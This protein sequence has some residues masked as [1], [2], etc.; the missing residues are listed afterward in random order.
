DFGRTIHIKKANGIS[1][2]GGSR[3]KSPEAFFRKKMKGK[4][5]FQSDIFAV[6]CVFYRLFQTK[7]PSWMDE[8]YL[9]NLKGLKKSPLEKQQN[10]IKK[11]RAKTDKRRSFLATKRTT[12]ILSVKEEVEFLVL[13]MLSIDP[14]QRS[15]AAKLRA[16]CERI[17]KRL[18]T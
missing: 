17:Y 7:L 16:E 4:D 6:G 5:Y 9:K 1:T 3:Y 18:E 10:F 11:I 14:V 2:Q 12:D 15:T 8:E 13:K